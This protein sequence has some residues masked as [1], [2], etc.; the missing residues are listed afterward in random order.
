MGACVPFC[1]I[2]AKF[3]L[4]T[5][6]VDS[7]YK[8]PY[9]SNEAPYDVHGSMEADNSTTSAVAIKSMSEPDELVSTAG[10]WDGPE[11]AK[12]GVPIV[13]FCSKSIAPG[14]SCIVQ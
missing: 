12:A 11:T 6:R 4:S 10:E 2:G 14:A 13:T 1:G 5:A 9:P 7:A 8:C 3:S